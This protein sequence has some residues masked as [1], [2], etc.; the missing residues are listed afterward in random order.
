MDYFEKRKNF[1]DR[2]AGTDRRNVYKL[3]YF[4]GGGLEKRRFK[5]RRKYVERREGWIWV[6]NCCSIPEQKHKS[7]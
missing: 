3:G 2:R 7:N 4:S 5:D 1:F 6:E